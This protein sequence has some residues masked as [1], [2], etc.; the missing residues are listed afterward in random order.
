ME[1]QFKVKNEQQPMNPAIYRQEKESEMVLLTY[2]MLEETNLVKHCFTTRM[3]GVSKGEFA[4]L[5][6][7]FTRGDEPEAVTANYRRV[8][9]AL[10]VEYESIV[11]SDQTHTTNVRMVTEA[12]RGCGLVKPRTYQDIDG[13]ITNVKG[14]TLATFYADC[15]PLYF[16][17]P[18]HKAIGLSHSGWRG[19]VERM[20][21]V[22]IELMC[23][24]YG[25][26][27]EDIVCA[28]G[29]S[30][31]K[32]CYEVSRDVADAFAKTFGEHKEQIL[33]DNGNGKFQLDLWEA[34]YQVLLDA[35]IQKRHIT[36]SNI[37]TCCNSNLLFSH[38]ASH[39]KR[40]NLGAFLCI[41]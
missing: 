31:C 3:G 39:G 38:R 32:D 15:V 27:P 5:N 1:Y 25:S 21:Q 17:D 40:G 18:V 11:C 13:L 20:G 28:I 26:R 4:T 10:E 22:T 7:S 23:K 8:A 36:K 16:V 12:D 19:T 6:L 14:L 30:I 2:P 35:G 37:C 24:T 33:S 29:P 34:N 9:A 41:K